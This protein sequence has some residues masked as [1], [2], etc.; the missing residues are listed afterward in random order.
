MRDCVFCRIIA[1]EEPAYIIYED[2]KA[3]A[4]LEHRPSSPGH[5]MVIPK[6]HGE[7]LVDFSPS[8]L[9]MVFRAVQTVVKA[10]EKTFA[11]TMLTIGTNY[12]EL[13]GVPHLHIHCIPRFPDD[14]GGII[15]SVVYNRPKEDLKTIQERIKRHI[16]GCPPVLTW[17]LTY[18]S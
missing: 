15:Q 17:R 13:S 7:T 2:D 9:S 14:G 11:T 8:E 10:L 16:Q 6:K 12:G 1:K 5:T 4:F 18:C 3:L